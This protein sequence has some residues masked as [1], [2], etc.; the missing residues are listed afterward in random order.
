MHG[1]EQR[2]LELDVG[3][4]HAVQEHVEL[5]NGLG[6][7]VVDLAAEAEVGGIAAGLLDELA[8]DDEHAAGAAGG[9][10]D[11]QARR[12]LEDVGPSGG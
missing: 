12:G 11:A 3:A 10:I 1:M 7:G 6:G 5:A 2:V 4:G 9:V 8:A